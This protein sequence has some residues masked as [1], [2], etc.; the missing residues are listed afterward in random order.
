M[1][2]ARILDAQLQSAEDARALFAGRVRGDDD[3]IDVVAARCSR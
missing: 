1:M 3:D 2:F